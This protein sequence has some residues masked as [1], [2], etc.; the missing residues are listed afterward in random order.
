VSNAFDPRGNPITFTFQSEADVIELRAVTHTDRE[1]LLTVFS[2]MRFDEFTGA[3]LS[4]AEIEL[5]IEQQ[6][7]MQDRYYRRHYPQARFDVVLSGGVA[8][9]RLYHNW[10]GDE[11]RVMDIALLPSF[12][13]RGIGARLMHGLIAQAAQRGMAVKLYVERNNPVRSLYIRLGFEKIGENGIYE[14]MCRPAAPF[15]SQAA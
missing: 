3:G 10:D 13:G 6:F 9:G 1:F 4:A 12:R 15:E 11:L 5:L 8:A 2:S 14:L 7:T